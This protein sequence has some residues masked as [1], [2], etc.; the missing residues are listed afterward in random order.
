MDGEQSE[1]FS[2]LENEHSGSASTECMAPTHA[3]EQCQHQNSQVVVGKASAK[4]Q[5]QAQAVK[6]CEVDLRPNSLTAN[7]SASADR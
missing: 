3:G 4:C 2:R 1:Q 5:V 6:Q 7:G